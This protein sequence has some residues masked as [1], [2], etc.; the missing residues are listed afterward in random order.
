[1]NIPDYISS[2]ITFEELH[3]ELT[4]QYGF[5]FYRDSRKRRVINHAL[6]A[7]LLMHKLRLIYDVDAQIFLQQHLDKSYVPL[8]MEF[9]LQK[10]VQ[11]LHEGA[12]K[13]P[14]YPFRELRLPRIKALIE[15][16]KIAAA[17]SRQA[18]PDKVCQTPP[19]TLPPNPWS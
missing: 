7:R 18:D 10:V 19:A 16:M 1:M 5:F 2:D 6:C 4:K 9:L 12:Q 11:L 17:F 3:D 14:K 15:E 13:T 8:R